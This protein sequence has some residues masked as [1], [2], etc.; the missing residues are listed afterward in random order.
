MCVFTS[1]FVSFQFQFALMHGLACFP[2]PLTILS[3][4]QQPQE[5]RDSPQTQ[6]KRAPPGG[7]TETELL[8]ELEEME[9]LATPPN[10]KSSTCVLL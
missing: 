3:R 8:M 2:V 6:G 7:G 5:P 4:E 10:K 1:R 9:E